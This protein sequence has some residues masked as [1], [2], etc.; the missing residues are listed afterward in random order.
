MLN[1]SVPHANILILVTRIATLYRFYYA[2]VLLEPFRYLNMIHKRTPRE[3][4]AK[5]ARARIGIEI[6]IDVTISCLPAGELRN[7]KKSIMDLDI[8]I[9]HTKR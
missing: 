7:A 3:L 8:E 4:D 9:A 2:P 5:L 1:D 6:Q